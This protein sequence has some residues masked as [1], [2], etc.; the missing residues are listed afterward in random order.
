MRVPGLS[1]FFGGYFR[2]CREIAARGD[3][4]AS[5]WWTSPACFLIALIAA[6]L[7]PAES[8][9]RVHRRAVAGGVVP[10]Y[11]ELSGGGAH[12]DACYFSDGA[13]N[14]GVA[15]DRSWTAGTDGRRGIC[16]KRILRESVVS[17]GDRG[18]V[19]H[20]GAAG[21]TAAID[22]GR[23]RTVREMVA[24]A[25]LAKAGASGN[26]LWVGCAAAALAVGGAKLEGAA[27]SSIPRAALQR[28]AGRVYAAGIDRLDQHVD[29]AF[30]RRLP[31]NVE[32]ERR[33]DLG[34]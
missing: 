17:G 5:V 12:G 31:S 7:A 11:G 20:A 22:L 13:G 16:R 21:N 15:G 3:A 26:L 9:R 27:Q 24:A 8:R 14:S 34:G 25:G 28:I 4:G 1:G 10:L 2:V 18:G 6:R 29:V 19:R 23:A 33:S 30:S 32:G